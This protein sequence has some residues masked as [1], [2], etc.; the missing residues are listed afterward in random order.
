MANKTTKAGTL[1]DKGVF[2]QTGKERDGSGVTVEQLR[3]ETGGA[4][5]GNPGAP[6][7]A[8]ERQLSAGTSLFDQTKQAGDRAGA[9]KPGTPQR[10]RQGDR[11]PEPFDTG[12]GSSR[13]SR[14]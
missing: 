13:G 9:P 7:G 4:P 11:V 12:R 1:G 3:G 8:L 5:S 2:S 10:E 14:R 6:D